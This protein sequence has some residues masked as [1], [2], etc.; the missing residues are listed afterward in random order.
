ML[1]WLQTGGAAPGLGV[2]HA[3]RGR[4]D[5]AAGNTAA[6]GSGAG[7][8]D[9]LAQDGA[10]G[11]TQGASPGRGCGGRF[12][13]LWSSA[14]CWRSLRGRCCSRVAGPPP[15]D[16]MSRHRSGPI[17][18]AGAEIR[19]YVLCSSAPGST[20]PTGHLTTGCRGQRTGAERMQ[21]QSTR[22]DLSEPLEGVGYTC[23]LARELMPEEYKEA[24]ACANSLVDE[25][26]DDV[27]VLT[28]R[29]FLHARGGDGR[30]AEED[31]SRA[32]ELAPG[33]GESY[34][35]RGL[36]RALRGEHGLAIEDF[37]RAIALDPD[38]AGLYEDRGRSRV[39]LGDLEGAIGDFDRAIELDPETANPFL[40]RGCVHTALGEPRKALEDLNRA[41]ELAA[42][43]APGLPLAYHHRGIALRRLLEWER[44]AEDFDRAVTLDPSSTRARYGRAAARINEGQL[45]EAVQDLDAILRVEPDNTLALRAVG[46]VLGYQGRHTAALRELNRSLRLD[47]DDP[48]TLS[49]RGVIQASLGR[50]AR[51]IEDHEK[52]VALDPGNVRMLFDRGVARLHLGAAAE[53]AHDFGA[54]LAIEP[55][56]V[57]ALAARA[58]ALAAGGM[59][60]EGFRD[61]DMVIR[62]AGD[63]SP[64]YLDQ[65][66][67]GIRLSDY[68][69][70]PADFDPLAGL[71]LQ[72]PPAARSGREAAQA[73][74]PVSGED[75]ARRG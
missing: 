53:A 48:E 63:G 71:S 47:P 7:R 31:L 6:A 75:G 4:A 35:N 72:R 46:V 1:P 68:G 16:G 58:M 52:A 40:P 3:G 30:R 74:K 62:L 56:N 17:R 12:R 11:D 9:G 23:S 28:G 32:I 39:D 69:R 70:S 10:G 49:A 21:D 45:L 73:G 15:R 64:S 38:S 22:K 41:I 59:V 24:V 19:T 42:D 20:Y 13:G 57:G 25:H 36:A 44:A 5:A 54:V 67:T 43:G 60:G 66:M 33:E 65:G 55:E 61:Y 26:P 2:V 50:H 8:P 34:R 27:P 18:V 14:C 29:G 51:A 37:D